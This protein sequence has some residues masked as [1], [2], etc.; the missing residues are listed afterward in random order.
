MV[1]LSAILAFVIGVVA[2]LM[3]L[4]L[5]KLNQQIKSWAMVKGE[6]IE[7]KIISSPNYWRYELTLKYR[8]EIDHQT[9]FGEKIYPLGK[10][11]NS[12]QNLQLFLNELSQ[13]TLIYYD[14]DNPQQSCL[15]PTP[16]SWFLLIFSM[17]IFCLL[18]GLVFVIVII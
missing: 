16:I 1:I 17:G 4:K 2:L 3:G 11:Y 18:I 14:P 12:Q 13:N 9:Y 7:S 15:K 5:R 6:I 10:I 8:Y